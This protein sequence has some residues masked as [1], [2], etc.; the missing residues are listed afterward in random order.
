[1][2]EQKLLAKYH[3]EPLEV[4]GYEGMFGLMIEIVLLPILTFVPCSFGP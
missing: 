1:V 4:V 3:L 2:F